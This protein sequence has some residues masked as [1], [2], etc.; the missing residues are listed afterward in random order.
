MVKLLNKQKAAHDTIL[1]QMVDFTEIIPNILL[2]DSF[3]V[4]RQRRERE[5]ELP[6]KETRAKHKNY[7]ERSSIVQVTNYYGS[8]SKLKDAR[9]SILLRKK[10]T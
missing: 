8:V 3:R 4:T 9:I 5:R 2:N 10:L 7:G 6:L 1:F